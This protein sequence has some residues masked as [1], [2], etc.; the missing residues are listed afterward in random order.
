MVA[1]SIPTLC[2]L[3]WVRGYNIP[4]ADIANQIRTILTIGTVALNRPAV[5]AGLAVLDAGGDSRGAGGSYPP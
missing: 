4:D 2:E 5:E 3:V 1:I